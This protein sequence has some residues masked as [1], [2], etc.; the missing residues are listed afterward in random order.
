MS[1]ETNLSSDVARLAKQVEHLQDL[2]KVTWSVVFAIISY[3]SFKALMAVPKM[4]SIYLDALGDKGKLPESTRLILE[5]SRLG[6]GLVPLACISG[7]VIAGFV[8]LGAIRNI[9][10]AGLA[11]VLC[12]TPLLVH[13]ILCSSAMSDP[14]YEIVRGISHS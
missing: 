10:I 7:L 1:Q 4:E 2:T 6:G 12:L 9:R 8:M 14:M 13:W 11:F 5:W 3:F